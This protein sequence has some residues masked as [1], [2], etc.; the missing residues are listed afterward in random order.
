MKKIL[1][2]LLLSL[3]VSLLSAQTADTV[4]LGAGISNQAYYSLLNGVQENDFSSDWDIAF[5]TESAFSTSILINPANGTELYLYPGD[6][7]DWLTLDTTGMKSTWTA[8]FNSDTSWDYGAFSQNQTSLHVGWGMYNTTT[9]QI[10]GDKLFVIKL[11]GGAYQKVWIR[12]L[13]SGIYTFN[14]ATLNNSM[15]MQHTLDKANFT[16]KNFGFYSLQTHGVK[17]KEPLSEDWDLYFGKYTAFVPTAYTVTG[18]LH[19]SQTESAKAYPVN[20][21]VNYIDWQAHSL[22]TSINTIGYDWKTF[23]MGTSTYDISDSTVYFVKTQ[24]GDVFKLVFT[25]YGG[26]ATGDIVFNKSHVHFAG[27]NDVTGPDMFEIYPNPAAEFVTAALY[28]E[29][30]SSIEVIDLN[31]KIVLTSVPVRGSL[32]HTMDI[33]SLQEGLY[34]V[35]LSSQNGS[36][37]KKMLVK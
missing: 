33:S 19:S 4:S 28:A 18:V 21:V 10:H 13:I 11:S 3:Y 37:V 17:D 12:S 32:I 6:T 34:I 30:E 23:N 25:H 35:R 16:G 20:D 14:H 5:Q 31:G 29:L 8:L 22:S 36:A 27:I 9:H 7:S 26:S 15:N 1:P 24:H 2:L